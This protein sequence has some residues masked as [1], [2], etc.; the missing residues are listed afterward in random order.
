MKG[1]TT[2]INPPN[3]HVIKTVVFAVKLQVLICGGSNF[4][5]C[6]IVNMLISMAYIYI[7]CMY[8]NILG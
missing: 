5:M 4:F 8:E 1:K 6:D 7:Y 3:R 2:G